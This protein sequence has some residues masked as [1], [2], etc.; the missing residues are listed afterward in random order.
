MK[1]NILS[2]IRLFSGL[3]I[4]AVGIVMTINANLGLGPWDAFH[5]GLSKITGLTMGRAHIITGI[6]L[7]VVD[8]LLGEKLGWGTLCNM[9]FIGIFMDILM[10]KNLIPT[11]NSFLPS[12]IMMLLGSFVLGFGSYLYI[13]VGLGSGPRDGLVVALTKKTN[14]SVGLVKNATELAVL[15]IGYLF[16]GTVGIG[17]FIMAITGGYSLQLAF[18]IVKFNVNEVEHRFIEDD[19]NF[20]KTKLMDEKANIK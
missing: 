20:I 14:K 12:L 4:C 13:S 9:L 11:F 5:Q 3:F 16:G 1:K 19:I 2:I 15:I 17:T 10:L 18:K 7:V 6:T 8:S